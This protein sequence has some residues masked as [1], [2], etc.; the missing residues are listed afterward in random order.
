M[1]APSQYREPSAMRM[2]SGRPV[3]EELQT[4]SG[5]IDPPSSPLGLH[6]SSAVQPQ[7]RQADY[8]DRLAAFS[9]RIRP[10]SIEAFGIA[11]ASLMLAT[12][13][14][15]VAGWSFS[16]LRFATYLPAILA[17]GLLAGVP[18]AVT[19]M[20]ASILIVVWAFIPPYFA[21][22]WLDYTESATV[23]WSVFASLFTI[24][25]AQGCRLVLQRLRAREASN[26]VL[27]QEL[28]H[29]G[30]NIFTVIEVILQKTLSDD[31]ERATAL[32]GRFRAVRYANELLI[33]AADHPIDLR[34]LLLQEFAPYGERQVDARGPQVDVDPEAARHLVLLFHELVTNAAKYG[35][36]SSPAGRIL[37]RWHQNGSGLILTWKEIGGPSVVVPTRHGFGTQLI[38]VCT[39]ALSGTF[40]PQFFP[41]GFACSITFTSALTGNKHA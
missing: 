36:L 9:E 24:F 14:R 41:E 1:S 35:A 3:K 19:V 30:R 17:T 33:A 20:T 5:L 25:F 39:R 12:A 23:I 29:R 4:M 21:F 11:L 38:N 22:K 31:P 32:L 40:D 7:E 2:A 10:L 13:V 26:R 6:N 37:V 34:T 18:A 28:A 8:L 27:V 16:D 15:F